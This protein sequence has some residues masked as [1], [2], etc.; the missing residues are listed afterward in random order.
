MMAPDGTPIYAPETGVYRQHGNDSFYLDG[1]S[2]TTYF[3][4]HLQEHVHADGPVNAGDLIALVGHTGNASPDGP[5]LHFEIHPGG[6]AAVDPY[7]ATA[8]AC[9][10]PSPEVLAAVGYVAE[11]GAPP[12]YPYGR[13]EVQRWYNRTHNPNIGVARAQRLTDYMNAVV[14]VRLQQYLL[15]VYLNAVQ[16]SQHSDLV[17]RWQGV[18]NC[19]SGGNW[20][21]NTGNGY[22]GGVQF[23]LSTWR[24]VGGSGYPHQNSPAEQAYRAE[25]LK[26]RSGLGQ[27]PVCGRYYRG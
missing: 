15:A 19:E 3:G 11:V 25:I 23:L 24:S 13:V 2:G 17:Y 18:A 9:T 10:G 4:T 20:A 8:A 16:S 27:W 22:Y 7:P 6:G 26:N 5:H 12:T 1:V 21:I 14:E